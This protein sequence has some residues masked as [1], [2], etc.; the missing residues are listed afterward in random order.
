MTLQRYNRT[1]QNSNVVLISWAAFGRTL[2]HELNNKIKKQDT[3]DSEDLSRNLDKLLS[4]HKVILWSVKPL[5]K[6]IFKNVRRSVI[7][8]SAADVQENNEEIVRKKFLV[9]SYPCSCSRNISRQILRSLGLSSEWRLKC[10]WAAE[11]SCLRCVPDAPPLALLVIS[12][13]VTMGSG[14]LATD[15]RMYP[16]CWSARQIQRKTVWRLHAGR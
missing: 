13:Q 10:F 6:I 3:G 7:I 16:P 12:H 8:Q 5:K 1:N 15:C 11:Y 9:S 2:I 14:W 4:T